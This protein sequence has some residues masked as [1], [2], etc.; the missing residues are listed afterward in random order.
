MFPLIFMFSKYK[1]ILSD[2]SLSKQ[3]I[4]AYTNMSKNS[5]FKVNITNTEGKV[6]LPYTKKGLLNDPNNRVSITEHT[7]D[8]FKYIYKDFKQRILREGF[9]EMI[10]SS[11][12]MIDYYLYTINIHE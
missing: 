8:L 4:T 9:K 2:N 11:D 1:T 10:N 7:D 5:N 3:A 6:I 12:P